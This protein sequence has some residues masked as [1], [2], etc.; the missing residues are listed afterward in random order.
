M[1]PGLRLHAVAG[2][3]DPEDAV[4]LHGRALGQLQYAHRRTRVH[5]DRS[6]NRG[7]E[8]GRRVRDLALLRERR[9]LGSLV[10]YH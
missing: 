1:A 9:L 7:E 8:I 2:V 10:S 5:P 6:Q 4:Q 3:I